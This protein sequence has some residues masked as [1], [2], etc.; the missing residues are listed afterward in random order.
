MLANIRLV[1]EMTQPL[2][3]K[4]NSSKSTTTSA[5]LLTLY[6]AKS[7]VSLY[8]KKLMTHFLSLSLPI[9][10]GIIQ[11]FSLNL[12]IYSYTTSPLLL[13]QIVS[14]HILIYFT[15]L[16]ISSLSLNSLCENLPHYSDK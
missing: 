14:F 13:A 2:I 4:F 15:A 7:K 10:V 16:S 3:T 5:H 9:F 6:R 8:Q 1:E 11:Y 12:S